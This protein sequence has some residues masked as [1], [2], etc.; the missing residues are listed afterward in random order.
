MTA[1]EPL[2]RRTSR[3]LALILL[4]AAGLE[5]ARG[6]R[7]LALALSYV[8]ILL[9]G[10]ALYLWTTQLQGLPDIGDPFDLAAFSA[11]EVPD[12]E[13]A[14]VVYRQANALKKPLDWSTAQ[15]PNAPPGTLILRWEDAEPPVQRWLQANRVA[16]NHWRVG[17][18][19]PKALLIPPAEL[20]YSSVFEPALELR[21]FAQ[22]SVLEATRHEQVG[23][24]ERAWLWYRAVLRC[25]RHAGEHGPIIQKMVGQTIQ[26]FAIN[27]LTTW[28]EDPRTDSQI[29]RQALEELKTLRSSLPPNSDALKVEYLA[30]LKAIDD[31]EPYV[32]NSH[33]HEQIMP[34][35]Y[36]AYSGIPQVMAFVRR[37]KERSRRV[38]QQFFASWLAYV[39][40]PS[41]QR[42]PL[43]FLDSGGS[44]PP[45]AHARALPPEELDRWFRST[46]L[47]RYLLPGYQNSLSVL[48]RERFQI[49]ALLVHVADQLYLREHG[50]PPARFEDLVGP[51]LDDLPPGYEGLG[52][53]PQR[54]GDEDDLE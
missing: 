49:D 31:S 9:S 23:E 33:L 36:Q 42:P 41:G 48:D 27:E 46:M 43:E 15:N 53:D 52:A 1:T 2:P 4:P 34:D 25:G 12:D 22:L 5:R 21:D 38:A 11:I 37:D 47:A 24:M 20:S 29:L 39:D 35:W 32:N 28:A 40:H 6:W 30:L 54:Y 19:R 45:A 10:S 8:L 18:E 50:Q 16:L 44:Y 13:N 51:Y 7:R 14:F 26:G 17:T 3:L